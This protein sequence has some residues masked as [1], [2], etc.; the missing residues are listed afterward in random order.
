MSVVKRTL[1]QPI[2]LTICELLTRFDAEGRFDLVR[3]LRVW[4][5]VVGEGIARRTEVVQL[6]FNVATVKVAGAMWLQ[7]LSLMKPQI[8]E[9]LHQ[10]LG[11]TTIKDLRFVQGRLS[12]RQ[13]PRLQPLARGLRRAIALPELAD[14]GLRQAFDSLIEAWGRAPR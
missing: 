8:L 7:E 6:K 13:T 12:R 11:A 14:P 2:G 1:P 4:P 3:L 10:V 9:R 5:E